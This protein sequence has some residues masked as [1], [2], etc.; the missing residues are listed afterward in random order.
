MR[1]AQHQEGSGVR[2]TGQ[3]QPSNQASY[4]NT[5]N[6]EP[7]GRAALLGSLILLFSVQAY[8]PNK[9]SCFVNMYVSSDNSFLSIG[10]EPA[11]G[12]WKVFP[13]LQHSNKT[14]SQFLFKGY[15]YKI[16]LSSA[17]TKTP[18]Q[19]EYRV[20]VQTLLTSIDQSLDTVDL[21]PSSRL[22]S[23]L[24][25]S[26]HEYA[27][28]LGLKSSQ[29][30]CSGRH[31]FGKSLWC[32]PDLLQVTSPSRLPW[33]LNGKEFTWQCRRHGFDPWFGKIPHASG[34]LSLRTTTT[35]PMGCNY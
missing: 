24:L 34:Q 12:P 10:Q 22:N 35:E 4:H 29:F 2:V 31:C 15:T 16:S 23:P 19:V 20:M 32:F 21:G 13:F 7:R 6:W 27:C 3:R 33:W 17:G 26:L 30:C 28:P 1:C 14:D 18:T 9:G 25:K 5:R 11:L 8:F